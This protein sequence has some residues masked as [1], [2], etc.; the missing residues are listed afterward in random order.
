MHTLH[1]LVSSRKALYLGASNNPAWIVSKANEY[2]RQQRLTFFAV[3]QDQWSTA[4][5][6]VERD[7]L[8][9]CILRAWLSVL[10]VFRDLCTFGRRPSEQR[11]SRN[12][13][14]HEKAEMSL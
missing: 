6:D 10:T 11:R 2:A 13:L 4:E 12:R 5:R 8:P 3:Y 9:M 14:Q 1:D 7:I